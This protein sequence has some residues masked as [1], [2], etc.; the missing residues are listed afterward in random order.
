MTIAK[1]LAEARTRIGIKKTGSN[2]FAKYGYYQ[3]D[4]IYAEA[5]GL[6]QEIGIVTNVRTDIFQVGEKIYQKFFLDVIN[7]DSLDEKITFEAITEP[8][9]MKGAQPCQEAGSTITYM[10]KYL[11]GLALMID[12]GRSDPDA[13]NDHKTASP[14]KT[15]LSRVEIQNKIKELPEEVRSSLMKEYMELEGKTTPVSETYWKQVFLMEVAKRQEW[16]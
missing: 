4:V 3:I 13:I 9:A 12:D 14:K 7:T 16:I 6:F 11:Y 2:S 8:N 5:K 15:S 10:S 1:K